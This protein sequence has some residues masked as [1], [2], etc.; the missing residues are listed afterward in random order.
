VQGGGAWGTSKHTDANGTTTGDFD[1]DGGFV[2]GTIGYN[3][4]SGTFVWGVEADLSAADISGSSV[5]LCGA[6]CS[7]NVDWFSTV[8]GRLGLDFN[9][10]MP[11]ITGGFAFGGVEASTNGLA[12]ASD[13]KTGWTVGGGV[14]F[15]V[16]RQWSVKAEYLFTD[17]GSIDVP[18]LVP[19]TADIDEIH[20]VRAGINYR[21]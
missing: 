5:T 9:G 8:R 11:F 13:T 1:I 10:F 2:G 18:T 7:T 16:D 3:F 15:K 17:L 19:T 14:E 21:F 4:Q 12:S 6:G 20:L